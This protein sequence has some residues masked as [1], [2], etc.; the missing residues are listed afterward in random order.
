VLAYAVEENDPNVM[1]YVAFIP[2][3]DTDVIDQDFEAEEQEQE[4]KPNA[5]VYLKHILTDDGST[6]SPTFNYGVLHERRKTLENELHE[7]E[8]SF[9]LCVGSTVL[10]AVMLL[11]ARTRQRRRAENERRLLTPDAIADIEIIDSYRYESNYALM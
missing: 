10:L 7:F 8:T 3:D 2:P 1:D 6:G 11:F 5:K 4:Q 9:M